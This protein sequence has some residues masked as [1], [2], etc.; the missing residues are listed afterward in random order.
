MNSKKSPLSLEA[1][2]LIVTIICCACGATWEVANI[3]KTTND[4]I[5]KTEERIAIV[6]NSVIDMK[7]ILNEVRLD[8]KALL[9]DSN[10]SSPAAGMARVVTNVVA[11]VP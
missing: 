10:V 9:H 1:I 7:T 2:A 6:E 4:R 3:F 5:G 11:F 8:V